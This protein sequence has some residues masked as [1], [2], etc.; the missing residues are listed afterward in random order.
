MD[1]DNSIKRLQEILESDAR[2]DSF[3][4]FAST[5]SGVTIEAKDSSVDSLKVRSGSGIGIRV[6]QEGRPGFSYSSVLDEDAMK[7]MATDALDSSLSAGKDEYLCFATPSE[8][9]DENGLS[10]VDP[11][12]EDVSEEELIENA[13]LIEKTVRGADPRIA[14]VRKATYGASRSQTRTVN[15]N[16]VDVSYAATFF[17][18]SVMAVAEEGTESQMGWEVAMAHC[19]KDVSPELIGEGAARRAVSLLKARQAKT[20]KC[21]AILENM[22]V[23]ELLGSLSVSFLSDNVLKGKSML[24]GKVGEQVASKLINLYDDGIMPGGWSSSTTDCE[25]TPRQRTPL[26]ACGELK[27][28]LYDTY[29][30][31][32]AGA[33][34]TGNASRGGFKGSPNVGS[35]NLYIEGGDTPFD[36]L[37][38]LMGEGLYIT[39]VMGVHTIDSISGDFSLGAA[40][41]KVEGGAIAY[42][43]RGLAI[44]GNLLELFKGVSGVASDLRFIGSVGAPSLLLSQIDAS[45]A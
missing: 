39:E 5:S 16:G 23:M 35:S 18:G 26:L 34:S 44:S 4:I 45:G 31:G 22:V 14:R 1:I 28:F 43:I 29:W 8:T 40:G 3:E 7:K 9:R 10:I 38:S 32:R 27:G 37:L 36:E 17:S 2:A 25:G 30:A 24:A 11:S 21:P 42:P 12:F 20:M 6:I 13:L 41:F 33:R 15:S 19:H